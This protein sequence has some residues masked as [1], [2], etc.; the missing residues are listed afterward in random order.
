MSNIF[1]GAD[2]E[3]F[4]KNKDGVVG[5]EKIIPEGGI[6]Y[7]LASDKVPQQE[8]AMFGEDHKIII[9]GVQAEMNIRATHCRQYLANEIA[10][11][12]HQL[13]KILPK[14]HTIDLSPL[15]E[16]SEQEFDSISNTHKGFGCNPS[17]NQ[18]TGG[19]SQITVDPF[20]VRERP[21]GGHIHLGGYRGDM[22][23]IEVLQ[24]VDIMVPVLDIVLG[25]TAV[26]VDTNPLNARRR[27]NYGRAGEYRLKPY[28]IEY[29]TV[30]N[31]WLRSYPLMG[32]VLG[33]AH[34]AYD[35]AQ[36]PLLAGELMGLV[37][38]EDI[39]NAINN[40]DFELATKNFDKVVDF[41]VDVTDNTDN[42]LNSKLLPKFRKFVEQGMMHYFDHDVIGH[43]TSL[44]ECH[45]EVGFEKFLS[46]V[47]K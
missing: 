22:E 31:F 44:G 4:F 43:W 18:Y 29:R 1:F 3:F 46:T 21:A 25:N 45:T 8:G 47:V 40:N 5:A 27:E 13:K 30:S 6:E 33:L 2:P 35:I 37:D 7:P 24:D 12:M 23:Q 9:D 16:V 39:R 41:I 34:Q 42:P 36:D 20:I 14:G 32:M 19:Q 10:L 28:G 17:Y 38:P 26:L 15:V 11:C